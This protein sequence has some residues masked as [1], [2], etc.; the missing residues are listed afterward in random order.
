MESL[1]L[2]NNNNSNEEVKN[3][4]NQ[5]EKIAQSLT[6]DTDQKN[7]N[8][9]GYDSIITQIKAIVAI[10]H[11]RKDGVPAEIL[12]N[13]YLGSVGAALSKK[14]LQ[15]LKITHVLSVMDKMKEPFPNV[16]ICE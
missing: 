14:I 8:K 16:I 12:P 15:N 1:A 13:L 2:N 9:K 4:I 11:M 5:E 3:M 6:T 10:S 7:E